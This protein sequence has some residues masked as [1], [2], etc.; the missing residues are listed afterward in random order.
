MKANVSVTITNSLGSIY[1]DNIQIYEVQEENLEQKMQDIDEKIQSIDE[2]IQDLQHNIKVDEDPNNNTTNL[3]QISDK[4]TSSILK[5][6]DYLILLSVTFI[7]RI[8]N[9]F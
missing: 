5:T 3:P 7:F 8:V 4:A 9:F 1:E 2:K 6:P